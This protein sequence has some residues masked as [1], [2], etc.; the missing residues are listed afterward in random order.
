MRHAN[1]EVIQ[2]DE[3]KFIGVPA[4]SSFQ[5]ITGIAEARN[6]FMDRKSE[7]EDITDTNTYTC[8]HFS[9]D[10]LFTYV[11]CL[12]V[13]ELKSIPNGMIGFTVPSHQY[14]KYRSNGDNP[15]DV[16]SSYLKENDKVLN[17]KSVSLEI[18]QFGEEENKYNADI[19]VP[20]TS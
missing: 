11:Y 9:N 16:I 12:E 20:I 13:E 14:A 10:V 1:V 5:N 6:M 15:Y 18:F 7:I 19:Y 2:L 3:K 4:T 8:V 17:S